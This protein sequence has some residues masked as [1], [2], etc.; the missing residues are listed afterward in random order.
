MMIILPNAE[1]LLAQVRD[2]LDEVATR[3]WD[4]IT[5]GAVAS[6]IA[7][8][9]SG[10]TVKCCAKGRPEGCR[11]GEWLYD[12]C[13]L[14][15][16]ESPDQCRF[17]TQALVIGEVEWVLAGAD[18]DFEKLLIADALVCFFL[19]GARSPS[20]GAEKLD[21]FEKLA[22]RRHE[23]L[24]QRRGIAQPPIFLVSCYSDTNQI[25]HRVVV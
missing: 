16:E 9:V 15:Y 13:A 10:P 12:F 14:L 8:R 4:K 19:F 20:L 25:S 3:E 7:K 11:Q 23:L 24:R 2:A 17:V 1:T 18:D 21:L 22:R 6:A 5:F